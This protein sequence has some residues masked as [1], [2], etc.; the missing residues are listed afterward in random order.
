M[1]KFL[2]LVLA[3]LLVLSM[4]AACNKQE[5]PSGE[6]EEGEESICTET[7]EADWGSFK[8]PKG[9]T[10]VYDTDEM[11]MLMNSSTGESVLVQIDGYFAGDEWEPLSFPSAVEF[12]DEMGGYF[13][14]EISDVKQTSVTETM[15]T[16]TFACAMDAGTFYCTVLL[17][18]PTEPDS[19]GYVREFFVT[20]TEKSADRELAKDFGFSVK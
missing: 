5:D 7:Y 8:Y 4:L 1:K 20:I 11:V 14:G 9:F 3:M 19:D 16:Y 18:C 12:N 13:E 10:K 17:Q 2:T 15:A 6:E